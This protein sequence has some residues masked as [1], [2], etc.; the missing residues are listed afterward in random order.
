[1]KV[2]AK[3]IPDEAAF[4]QELWAIRKEYYIP[5][6][7]NEYWDELISKIEDIKNRH[8]NNAFIEGC[9]LTLARDCEMRFKDEKKMDQH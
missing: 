9:L 5:E 2:T 4:F 6:E 1:M 3:D 7:R 8:P